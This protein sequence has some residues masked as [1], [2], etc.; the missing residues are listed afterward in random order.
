MN[1]SSTVTRESA[2]IAGAKFTTKKMSEGIRIDL[3]RKLSDHFHELRAIEAEEQTF[4]LDLSKKYEK[5]AAEIL[6]S[7]L[8]PEERQDLET[9][10]DR[11][12]EIQDTRINPAYFRAGFVRIEGF[13]ID[14]KVPDADA[15]IAA[16]PPAL[17]RE[18][19]AA[20]LEDAGLTLNQKENLESP[21]TSSAQVGGQTNASSA[22]TAGASSSTPKPA[23]AGN[24]T[25]S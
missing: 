23:T 12:E 13:E 11:K 8:N 15:M 9:Y 6:L 1:Y 24:T 14:G 19:H 22:D 10:L 25:Q 20:I 3:R 21:T 2:H 17:V 16:A 4:L 5:P 7:E 18:I